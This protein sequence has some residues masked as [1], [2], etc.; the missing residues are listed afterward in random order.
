MLTI[1][2]SGPPGSGTTTI[3]KL[4]SKKLKLP[5]VY[6]G[7]IFRREAERRGMAL[8]D[9]SKYCE[10]NPEI[11]KSLDDYQ[12]EILKKG[13][14]I[15]EGRLAGWIA[16]LN[17]IPAFKVLLKADL[18]IRISRIINREGGNREEKLKEITEREKSEA[19][20]YREFYG[21]NINDET[22]YD[23]VIDTSDK[24]PREIVDIIINELKGKHGK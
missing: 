14:V 11:D 18:D 15:M 23:L 9:F 8:H 13:N 24:S 16:H 7:E 3:S 1:T 12:K 10:R 4:L 22:I 21:I 19:K 5:H 20:R 6:A 17:N 2:V